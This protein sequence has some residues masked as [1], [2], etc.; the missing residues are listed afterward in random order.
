MKNVFIIIWACLI[1]SCATSNDKLIGHADNL[2]SH[3]EFGVCSDYGCKTYHQTGLTDEEWKLVERTFLPQAQNPEQERFMIA[4]AIARI[5]QFVGPKIGTSNDKA[6]AVV[7][8]FSTKGQMDCIDEAFNT[9]SYLYLMRQ[10]GFI[11]FHTLGGHLR[12]NWDNLTYPHSTA[13]IHEIGLEQIIEGPGHYVVDSW[14]HENGA[15]AEI[16]PA[17]QWKT[18]WY[19]D[20]KKPRYNF[21][22]S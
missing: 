12:R 9:T 22:A 13:T 7:I 8:N 6:R 14:F 5:E 11:K 1:A 19:P 16:M 18:R 10:A 15:L 2:N 3:R 21:S 17:N 20:E 4:K